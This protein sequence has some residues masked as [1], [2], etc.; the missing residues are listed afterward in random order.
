MIF[1]YLLI[2]IG[3]LMATESSIHAQQGLEV[4]C[5]NC[6]QFDNSYFPETGIWRNPEQSGTGFML[7]VQ[8]GRLGGFYYL[9]DE[10][11]SPVWYII[12]GELH[13]SEIEG[14]V[15]E[16]ETE[17]EHFRNGA[18]L[19]CTYEPPEVVES[20]GLI[21]LEFLRRNL[22]RFSVDGGEFQNVVPLTFGVSGSSP[23]SPETQY[24]VPDLEGQWVLVGPA[25]GRPRSASVIVQAERLGGEDSGPEVAVS[26]RLTHTDHG[27]P[28]SGI[29]WRL[30]CFSEADF[31]PACE[32]DRVGVEERWFIPLA[33]LGHRRFVAVQV[34]PES[35]TGQFVLEGFRLDFD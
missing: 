18:C 7:E 15:W 8:N 24:V 31:G 16:L 28:P 21:R 30:D 20:P 35:S 19:N 9:Y 5:L 11:G 23:F 12:A 29:I 10:A 27:S 33:N 13:L 2:L 32:L 17:L 1:R 26:Y 14:V 3:G 22:A 6:P 25:L 34:E 4:P